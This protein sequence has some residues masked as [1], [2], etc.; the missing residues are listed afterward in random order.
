MRKLILK[1]LFG[2]D[3]KRYEEL[4]NDHIELLHKCLD[5]N[6]KYNEQIQF[7]L[8]TLEEERENLD[9]IRKLII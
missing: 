5:T 9:I 7:H 8:K 6:K 1:W 4:L 3:V 2:I